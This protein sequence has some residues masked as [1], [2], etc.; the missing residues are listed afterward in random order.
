ML[1]N[2]ALQEIDDVVQVPEKKKNIP[3]SVKDDEVLCGAWFNNSTDPKLGTS[4]NAGIF[5]DKIVLEVNKFRPNQTRTRDSLKSRWGKIAADVSKYIGCEGEAE[6][7]FDARGSGSGPEDV[8]EL[9]MSFFT[10]YGKTAKFTLF[11]CLPLCK[12]NPKFIFQYRDAI[13]NRGATGNEAGDSAPPTNEDQGVPKYPDRPDGAKKAKKKA[14]GKGK[15][16]GHSKEDGAS[17]ASNSMDVFE[18]TIGGASKS[19]ELMAE[20][21]REKLVFNKKKEEDY[22]VKLAAQERQRKF[23]R[24]QSKRDREQ[25]ERDQLT[26][27]Q[28]TLDYLHNKPDKTPEEVQLQQKLRRMIYGDF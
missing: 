3:Y 14:S 20:V 10:N 15:S 1:G 11:H 25:S 22:H 12:G 24:A 6:R 27:H 7:H 4:Q 18:S 13:A 28:R 2:V 8:K 9:A 16:S 26:L 19:A 17:S 21:E 5:W 23:L